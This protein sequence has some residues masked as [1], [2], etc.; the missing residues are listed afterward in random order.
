[1]PFGLSYGLA[2]NACS[3][4]FPVTERR[5]LALESL[6]SRSNK[7]YNDMVQVKTLIPLGARVV[8][9]VIPARIP[10]LAVSLTDSSLPARSI[11]DR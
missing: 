2:R 7:S 3:G 11:P 8:P 10:T 4:I 9:V 5:R 6:F 1:M